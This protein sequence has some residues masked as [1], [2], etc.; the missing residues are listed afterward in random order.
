MELYMSEEEICRCYRQAAHKRE[1]I[2][3]LADLNCTDRSTI[4]AVLT[5]GGLLQP[6]KPLRRRG[7]PY[8]FDEKLE[9]LEGLGLTSLELAQR[10]GCSEGT[11]RDW[12]R[13][14]QQENKITSKRSD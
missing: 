7:K 11:V 14:R 13:R 5:E 8:Q 4:Q 6:G 2:G 1:I 10:V 12:R 9:A 3:I